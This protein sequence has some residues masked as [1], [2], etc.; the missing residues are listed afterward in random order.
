M[1]TGSWPSRM[2]SFVEP[3]QLA[4]CP[5]EG[6]MDLPLSVGLALGD[7]AL[8]VPPQERFARGCDY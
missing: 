6:R 3:P 5:K 7:L 8:D 1:A 2:G 4:G